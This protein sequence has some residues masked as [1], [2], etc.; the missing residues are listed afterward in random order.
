MLRLPNMLKDMTGKNGKGKNKLQQLLS[1]GN[2]Y[3]D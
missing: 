3:K 1:F 2:S